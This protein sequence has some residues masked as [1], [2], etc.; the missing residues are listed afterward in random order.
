MPR[1]GTT[2]AQ[3]D[4]ND[5]VELRLRFDE[6]LRRQIAAAANRSLR[7]VNSEIKFRLQSSFEDEMA[8]REGPTPLPARSALDFSSTDRL[9]PVSPERLQCNANPIK[10]D[11]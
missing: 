5:R 6:A 3:R 9:A 4:P 11:Q 7:S 10:S 8:K 2:T 1:A